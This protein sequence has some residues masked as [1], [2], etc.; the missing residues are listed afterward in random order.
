[1][2]ETNKALD[3]INTLIVGCILFLL[4]NLCK[5]CFVFSVFNEDA[6]D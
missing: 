5:R 2:N 6:V 1:M 4:L 3:S